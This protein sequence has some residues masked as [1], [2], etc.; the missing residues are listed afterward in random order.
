MRLLV[1]VVATLT[2]ISSSFLVDQVEAGSKRLNDFNEI[3]SLAKSLESVQALISEDGQTK[4]SQEIRHDQMKV[5]V[6]EPKIA[7]C[8]RFLKQS[9]AVID[10]YKGKAYEFVKDSN[11][12]K[13]W[14]S[15][16]ATAFAGPINSMRGL[17]KFSPILQDMTERYESQGKTKGFL[18]EVDVDCDLYKFQIRILN[19]ILFVLKA[20]IKYL[21]SEPAHLINRAIYERLKQDK[22]ISAHNF[23]EIRE[24][25]PKQR[26][27][28]IKFYNSQLNLDAIPIGQAID[29]FEQPGSYVIGRILEDC[30]AVPDYVKSWKVAEAGRAKV[31]PSSTSDP[32][33]NMFASEFKETRYAE[34]ASFCDSFSKSL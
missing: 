3:F 4:N 29:H 20:E 32:S 34:L 21:I 24:L 28:L 18:K 31:C 10:N 9:Q 25:T 11:K 1:L 30:S 26:E 12:S 17:S 27:I 14:F 7:H 8:S 19:Q 13:D 23:F 22:Y 33:N 5:F 2:T 15:K 6:G 16:V